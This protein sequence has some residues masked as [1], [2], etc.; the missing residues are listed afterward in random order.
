MKVDIEEEFKSL[1]EAEPLDLDSKLTVIDY[2]DYPRDRFIPFLF[3]K[4]DSTY[5]ARLI[6]NKL[7]KEKANLVILLDAI[8]KTKKEFSMR[9]FIVFLESIGDDVG[10]LVLV[11]ETITKV[12]EY[13]SRSL[14][15][16]MARHTLSMCNTYFQ[17]GDLNDHEIAENW[18]KC[19]IFVSKFTLL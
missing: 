5:R 12:K 1:R 17:N 13:A 2:Q 8:A 15:I 7:C 4:I 6:L 10:R 19:L 3:E 14:I 9:L 11:L 16:A 18:S